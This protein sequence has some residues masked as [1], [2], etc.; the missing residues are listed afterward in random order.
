MIG[1]ILREER[2]RQGLTIK[3]IERE[4]SIRALYIDAIEKSDDKSLPSEVYVRGFIKNYATFLNLDVDAV[5][6]YY[7]DERKAVLP[8][9]PAEQPGK[10]Q[11]ENREMFSSGA[12]FKERVHKSHRAQNIMIVAVLVI[13]AF[14]GSIY[15]F[16]GD[17]GTKKP[18]VTV[19][20]KSEKTVKQEPV[21]T[22]TDDKKTT[23]NTE[24]KT[25][26]KP[27]EKV[28]KKDEKKSSVEEKKSDNDTKATIGTTQANNA[29][30]TGNVN[31]GAVFSDYC[32]IQVVADGK[33]V[34]EGTAD[35]GQSL[36]WAANERIFILIG[37]AGAV[38]LTHNGKSL[39][40]GGKVG[41]VI[42]KTFTVPGARASRR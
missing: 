42:E 11:P 26:Q 34:F 25:D 4:T 41:E 18:A 5:M 3:D 38:E 39:G 16:F 2:E 15:Y 14:V 12:D 30:K 40:K 22:K 9:M 35:K 23:V 29:V 20:E 1:D 28:E 17:D 8:E 19:A 7:R 13:C 37:N 36:N 31:V 24:K 6:Q 27:A 33:T 21:K 32:W 10:K